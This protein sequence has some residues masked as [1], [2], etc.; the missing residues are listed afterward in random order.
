MTFII[1]TY[2][3]KELADKYGITYAAWLDWIKPIKDRLG[4]AIRGKWSP[5]QVEMMIEHF[6]LPSK[7]VKD[8]D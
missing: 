3:N 8:A 5:N 1:K 2:T 6:G 4:K 7:E